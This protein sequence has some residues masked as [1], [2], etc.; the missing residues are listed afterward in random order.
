MNSL[1]N[2]PHHVRFLAE[3]KIAGPRYFEAAFDSIPV[4]EREA[5]WND[6][7]G[8]DSRLDLLPEDG[9]LPRGC[10]PYLPCSLDLIRLA[11]RSLDIG[12]E[13]VFIDVGSGLGR[14]TSL[15]QLLT[16]ASVIGIE[17]QQHLAK[18]A[19]HMSA[20]FGHGRNVT[21][22]GDA[23]ELLHYLPLGT[24]YFLYCPCGGERLGK[25]LSEIEYYAERRRIR[26]ACVDMAPLHSDFLLPL[27][28]NHHSL[29]LYQSKPRALGYSGLRGSDEQAKR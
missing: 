11:V 15:V 12:P 10:A 2:A 27:H 7:W 24:V 6:V 25:I 29:R 4:A 9:D 14:T 23:A 18:R 21:L 26:V 1:W 13:D 22:R 17:I 8:G 3:R 16:G 28:T 5:W 20:R 19:T